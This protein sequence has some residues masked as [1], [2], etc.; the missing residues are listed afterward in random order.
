MKN[1]TYVIGWHEDTFFTTEIRA[2]NEVEAIKKFW[3]TGVDEGEPNGSEIEGEPS[4][5]EVRK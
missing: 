1:K 4:V 3:K 2:R 5:I